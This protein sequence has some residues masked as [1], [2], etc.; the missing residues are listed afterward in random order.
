MRC[1]RPP[2]LWHSPRR[3]SRP[4]REP[5]MA[6]AL[7]VEGRRTWLKQH[8]GERRRLALAVLDV[9]VRLLGLRCLRP[10]PRLRAG[11]ACELEHRRL[12]EL[13]ARGVPVPRVL[14][15]GE[16]TLLL[17]DGGPSLARLLR[18]A[19]PAEAERLMGLAAGELLRAHPA[20]SRWTR[21]AAC[22]SSIWKKTRC[23][24]SVRHARLPLGVLA[25]V[26]GHCLRQGTP[27][28]QRQVR[29]AVSRLRFL[30]ALC[31]FSGRRAQGLGD[32]VLILRRALA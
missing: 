24:G 20:I 23:S 22:A 7:L 3:P 28:V 1:V 21:R 14:G 10:P 5:D 26:I 2:D 27:E 31:R 32:S 4:R 19:G 9:V 11:L 18:R 6:E 12:R 16:A 29:G 13:A 8:T 17:E 30:P 25:A 15:H